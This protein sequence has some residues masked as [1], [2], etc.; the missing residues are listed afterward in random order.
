MVWDLG[1]YEVVEGSYKKG[2][3]EVY[4]S[5]RKLDGEWSLTNVDGSTWRVGN[6]TGRLKRG[7][8]GASSALAGMET[9]APKSGRTRD[10]R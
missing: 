10:A 8:P 7:L 2:A 4:L 9:S 5:G 6:I 3:L 1:T